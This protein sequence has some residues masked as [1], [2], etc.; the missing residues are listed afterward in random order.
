MALGRWNCVDG[1]LMANP[2]QDAH[3]LK[4]VLRVDAVV[5]HH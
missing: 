1:G 2:L 5:H 4:V 3:A